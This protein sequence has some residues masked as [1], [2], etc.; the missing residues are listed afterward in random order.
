MTL[1]GDV[2]LS[3]VTALWCAM[4]AR[5]IEAHEG[6]ACLEWPN[7]AWLDPSVSQLGREHAYEEF[8]GA[9]G[10]LA[11]PVVPLLIPNR[12]LRIQL[13]QVGMRESFALT[14][15]RAPP[16]VVGTTQHV[17]LEEADTRSR[18]LE[19][20]KVASESFGYEVES[21]VIER[22]S[23]ARAGIYLARCG[24]ESIGSLLLFATEQTVGVHMVGVLPAHRRRGYAR[25]IMVHAME[26]ACLA[27]AQH[28]VLQAA[29]KARSL[30][31]SLGFRPLFDIP[32]YTRGG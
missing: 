4:G 17:L 24:G 7:R 29:P 2:N 14:A 16:R 23:R 19:W 3:N 6:F 30:Y 32:H 18:I 25:Q 5:A 12:E 26:R 11:N 20:T 8:A 9:I 31:E 28:V 27:S 15:M 13:A 21:S 10:R 1:E 22:V